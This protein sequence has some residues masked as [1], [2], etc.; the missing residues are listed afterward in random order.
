MDVDGYKIVNV[1][2]PLPTR[3]QASDLPVFPRPCLYAGDF[4]CPHAAWDYVAKSVDGECL[5]GWARVNN[6]SHLFN[7]KDS[8]SFYSGRRNSGTNRDLAFASADSDS[9]LPDKHALEKFP[10]SQHRPSLIT[11]QD[12]LCPCQ[13]CS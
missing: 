7:S 8:A 10:K 11:Q 3:L 9:C 4:S 5:A 2:K 12:L 6:L 13:A 1:Y